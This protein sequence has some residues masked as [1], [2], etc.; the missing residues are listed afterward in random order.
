MLIIVPTK[1]LRAHNVVR[2]TREANLALNAIRFH[3]GQIISSDG[4]IIMVSKDALN[5]DQPD[6]LIRVDRIPSPGRASTCI[7]DTDHQL[8]FFVNRIVSRSMLPAIN[9]VSEYVEVSGARVLSYPY[10]DIKPATTFNPGRTASIKVGAHVMSKLTALTKAIGS[11]SGEV[12]LS[13]QNDR[14]ST[15]AALIKQGA[16]EL[17]VYFKPMK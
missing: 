9:L 2:G 7:I 6:F 17:N 5:V 16:T 1:V 3:E 10:P 12:T 4:R 11:S 14:N 15:V 13:F 8:A